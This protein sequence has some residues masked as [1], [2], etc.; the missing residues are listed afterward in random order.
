MEVSKNC[1]RLKDAL[2]KAGGGRQKAEGSW[3]PFCNGDL[4]SAPKTFRLKR[5]GLK[6]DCFD[7]KAPMESSRDYFSLLKNGETLVQII[8]Y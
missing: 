5:Q 4:Y 3:N 6:L 2:A 8:L 1:R 7:E